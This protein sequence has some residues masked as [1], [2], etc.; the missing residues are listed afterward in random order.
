MNSLSSHGTLAAKPTAPVNV[1]V[2][3][4]ASRNPVASGSAVYQSYS[5][6]P[7]DQ[8]QLSKDLHSLIA[9][10]QNPGQRESFQAFLRR[11][12]QPTWAS[13]WASPELFLGKQSEFMSY[14][15]EVASEGVEL[16]VA[17]RYEIEVMR[18]I[19]GVQAMGEVDQKKGYLLERLAQLRD[20][21]E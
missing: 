10:F 14:A 17:D 6:V 11:R 1:S 20:N 16:R 9:T 3:Q 13:L 19:E 21:P 8:R 2:L 4:A 15:P 12:R 18:I 5:Q 7:D